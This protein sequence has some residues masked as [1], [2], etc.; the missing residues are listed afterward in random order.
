MLSCASRSCLTSIVLLLRL[1]SAWKSTIPTT[2]LPF[3]NHNVGDETVHWQTLPCHDP[4]Q[5]DAIRE[6]TDHVP[7]TPEQIALGSMFVNPSIRCKLRETVCPNVDLCKAMVNFH[8]AMIGESYGPPLNRSMVAQ[9]FLL[10]S[11]TSCLHDRTAE[12]YR[13]TYDHC[14]S[15]QMRPE[16]KRRLLGCCQT[17][18][19]R[20]EH[21]N[22]MNWQMLE[23]LVMR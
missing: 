12:E 11:S 4:F 2:T 20:A 15:Y 6:A 22:T 1:Q 5:L 23:K 10:E 8:V 13:R 7:P 17:R 21:F 18:T 9:I 3:I 16:E 14:A 19:S